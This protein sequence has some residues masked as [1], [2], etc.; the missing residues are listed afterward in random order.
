MTR[1]RKLWLWLGCVALLMGGSGLI[2]AALVPSSGADY[3]NV[4]SI[5]ST[6]EYQNPVL[7]R[8]AWALPV[9]ALYRSDIDYQRNASVCGPT[10]IVNVLHSLKRP[11]NQESVLE[12]TGL[13]TVLGY[14]PEGVTLDQLAQIAIQKLGANVT[15]LR[16]LD[17]ASF[18][19][20]LSH[21]NDPSRRY[22]INFLRGPLFGTGGG[23]HS[24]IAGYLAGEDLVLVLDVNIK[25]G[26]WL[27]KS[28]RLFEA[29]NTVDGTSQKKRGLLLIE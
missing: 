1:T 6:S 8:Q 2:F 3:A 24:P 17:L 10:S 22:I 26:P 12:D 15:V 13:T 9:A 23:H 21:A 18:R 16:N 7:L 20:Q 5:K 28:A 29:M 11:G 27:V 4:L 14:L 25:Y 19:E